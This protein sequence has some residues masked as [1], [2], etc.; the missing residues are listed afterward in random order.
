V[1]LLGGL[2]TRKK[3]AVPSE[4]LGEEK[5]G[6]ADPSFVKGGDQGTHTKEVTVAGVGG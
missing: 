6:E 4:K 2:Q 1:L 3:C 5:G